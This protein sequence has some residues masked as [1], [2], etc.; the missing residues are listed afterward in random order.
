MQEAPRTAPG[1]STHPESDP[2]LKQSITASDRTVSPS[3][4]NLLELPAEI[5]NNIWQLTGMLKRHNA[6]FRLYLLPSMP[7]RFRGRVPALLHVCRQIRQDTQAMYW[8]QVRVWHETTVEFLI[9][10]PAAISSL[11]GVAI[12]NLKTVSL[13]VEGSAD[14]DVRRAR[15]TIER[16]RAQLSNVGFRGTVEIY[17][18]TAEMQR[19]NM[20]GFTSDPQGSQN[21]AEALLRAR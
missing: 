4:S 21:K 13:L 8:S 18:A 15:R 5:R 6:P 11:E 3:E 17:V 10:L 19:T 20:W 2:R 7:E 12:A 1:P 9:R 14:K 16:Y